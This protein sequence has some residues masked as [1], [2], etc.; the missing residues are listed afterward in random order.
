MKKEF[1]S[2]VLCLCF[3]FPIES[4]Y[5]SNLLSGYVNTLLMENNTLK[6]FTFLPQ[7]LVSYFTRNYSVLRV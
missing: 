3:T 7:Y 6:S 2:Y 4:K 1:Y 5:L